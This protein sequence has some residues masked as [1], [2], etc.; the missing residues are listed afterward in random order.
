MRSSR[1]GECVLRPGFVVSEYYRNTTGIL[2][3][4]HRNRRFEHKRQK[5]LQ[6]GH[7][8]ALVAFSGGLEERA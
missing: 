5:W 1:A 4:H 6:K 2:P 3:K 7:R 8:L